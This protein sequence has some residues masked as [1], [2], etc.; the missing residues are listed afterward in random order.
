MSEPYWSTDDT[1]YGVKF[2]YCTQHH[3][4]HST[5]WCT[6]DCLSKVPLLSETEDEANREWEMKKQTLKQ[7]VE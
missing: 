5:G 2:V 7:F 4:V 1:K 6:V 3:R